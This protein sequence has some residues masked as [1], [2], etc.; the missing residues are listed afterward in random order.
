M[1][2]V[3]PSWLVIVPFSVFRACLEI[4]LESLLLELLLA[5]KFL[6]TLFAADVIDPALRTFKE[7][8]EIMR[9]SCAQGLE[10][11]EVL[12]GTCL[13]HHSWTHG[14]K[15]HRQWVFDFPKNDEKLYF[16]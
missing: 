1:S 10:L 9:L 2:T 7:L 16:I 15:K 5:Q 14:R 11:L 4:H 13:P 3:R 8:Q 6:P 12:H